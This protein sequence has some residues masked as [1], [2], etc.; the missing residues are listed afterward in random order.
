MISHLDAAKG[1]YLIK[2]YDSKKE[3]KGIIIVRG[4]SSTNSLIQLLPKLK[5]KG[6][7]VKVVA[8]ISWELFQRQ[9]KEY[10]NFVISESEWHD[11]MIITNGALQLMYKWTANRIVEE[12]SMSSDFDNRW[13]TGGSLDQ[14]VAEAHLDPDSIWKGI[15]RFAKNRKKRLN[16]LKASLPI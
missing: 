8:A 4:T 16:V 5:E 15:N 6:P 11:A 14:I 12:Y 13:R 3:K 9:S 10:R 1:A 7:N 2:D